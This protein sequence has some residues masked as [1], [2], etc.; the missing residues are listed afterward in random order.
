LP[1]LLPLF[2]QFP[3][4]VRALLPRLMQLR[5]H[6]VTRFIVRRP[7]A[8]Q[9]PSRFLDSPRLLDERL[10]IRV[11][12]L[13]RLAEAVGSGGQFLLRRVQAFAF[14]NLTGAL[15][16][17]F[18]SPNL[19]LLRLLPAAPFKFFPGGLPLRRLLAVTLLE[20]A[21]RGPLRFQTGVR[22]RVRRP[23][24]LDLPPSAIQILRLVGQ[25]LAV[26][27]QLPAFRFELIAVGVQR[28]FPSGIRALRFPSVAAS[29][30]LS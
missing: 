9:L 5:L 20:L 28:M 30:L 10:A 12:L 18:L 25:R 22:R 29:K 11:E 17:E 21:E 1:L 6:P 14:A 27:L 24:G 15:C 26:S 8:L 19:Q 2:V 23:V 7:V 16:F 3:L 4:F 13:L